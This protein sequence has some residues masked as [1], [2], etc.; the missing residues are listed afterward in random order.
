[1]SRLSTKPAK[2]VKSADTLSGALQ[3]YMPFPDNLEEIMQVSAVSVKKV[4]E[5]S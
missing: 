4:E 5:F 3:S 2:T 1:M